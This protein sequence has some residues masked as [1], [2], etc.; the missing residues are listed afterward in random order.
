MKLFFFEM[1]TV[2][3]TFSTSQFPKKNGNSVFFFSFIYASGH[4]GLPFLFISTSKRFFYKK[5]LCQFLNA[6]SA[7]GT[8]FFHIFTS[9]YG[10]ST[11]TLR[12]NDL[13]LFISHY[14]RYFRS[15]FV[16]RVYLSTCLGHKTLEEHRFLQLEFLAGCAI[17]ISSDC[18][19]FS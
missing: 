14:P 19:K 8:L 3:C 12:H 4:K 11:N 13:Q 1:R 17:S 10:P 6:K 15:S 5:V 7:S 2:V 18:R 16:L 9:K